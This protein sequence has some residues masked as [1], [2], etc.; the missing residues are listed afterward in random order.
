MTEDLELAVY[1]TEPR[2]VLFHTA[3][4]APKSTRSTQGVQL[5]TLKKNY[6]PERI[7]PVEETSIVNKSRYRVRA[8]PAAGALLKEEDSEEKQIGLLE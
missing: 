7:C 4:L 6:R 1:S 5:I 3:L 2:V 8:L